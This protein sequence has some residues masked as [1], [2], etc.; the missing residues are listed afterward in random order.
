MKKILPAMPVES[1]E[2]RE[3]SRIRKIGVYDTYGIILIQRSD[4]VVARL[5]DGL[6]MS[7]GD[8]ACRS[9]EC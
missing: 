5:L 6:H 9:Y 1:F 2:F 8:V 7:R 4:K 3:K